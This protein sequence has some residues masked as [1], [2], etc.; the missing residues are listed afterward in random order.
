MT[1]HD[2][3]SRPYPPSKA[4]VANVEDKRD[5]EKDDEI[6]KPKTNKDFTLMS[7]A[8]KERNRKSSY[9]EADKKKAQE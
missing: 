5:A 8:E 3:K 1:C 6:W 2:K 4:R 7:D 9:D